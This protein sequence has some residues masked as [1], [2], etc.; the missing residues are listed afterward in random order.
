MNSCSIFGILE[1]LNTWTLKHLNTW[2]LEHWKEK[3]FEWIK[4]SFCVFGVSLQTKLTLFLFL[5]LYLKSIN[6]EMNFYKNL[7]AK[8]KEVHNRIC[9]FI[10]TNGTL[11]GI[12]TFIF[13]RSQMDYFFFLENFWFIFFSLVNLIFS[14]MCSKLIKTAK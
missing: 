13:P 8:T 9:Y 2:T 14:T 12:N 1:H 7:T 4:L 11:I 3:G 5:F 10:W 6:N